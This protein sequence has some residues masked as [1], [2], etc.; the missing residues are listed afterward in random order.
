MRSSEAWNK[1]AAYDADIHRTSNIRRR[2]N[3]FWGR[4]CWIELANDLAMLED[5]ARPNCQ[6]TIATRRL[7]HRSLRHGRS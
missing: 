3:L 2:M 1:A 4:D 7:S 6:D 5:A